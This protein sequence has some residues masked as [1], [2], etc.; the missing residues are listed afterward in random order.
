MN[1]LGNLWPDRPTSERRIDKRFATPQ[2][3]EM[4]RF[5]AQTESA[6]LG[7][8]FLQNVVASDDGHNGRAGAADR[9][10]CGV[11]FGWVSCGEWANIGH[12]KQ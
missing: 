3:F 4:L 12:S 6:S 1:I 9:I 11:H 7:A 10:D 8:D 5:A 2:G